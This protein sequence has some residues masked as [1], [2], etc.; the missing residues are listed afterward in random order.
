LGVFVELN[1]QAHRQ[2][3]HTSSEFIGSKNEK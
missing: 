2:P 1:Y 3:L